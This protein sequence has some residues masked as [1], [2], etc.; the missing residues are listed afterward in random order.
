MAGPVLSIGL[1][2]IFGGWKGAALGALDYFSRG[3]QVSEGP[4]LTDRAVPVAELGYRIPK[5]YGTVRTAGAMIWTPRAGLTEIRNVQRG[6]SKDRTEYV[7]YSYT[8][9][10]AWC[11]C[12]PSTRLRGVSYNNF[13]IYSNNGTTEVVHPSLAPSGQSIVDRNGDVIPTDENG[14]A[15]AGIYGYKVI[16]AAA[17]TTY[18]PVTGTFTNA[19]F[20]IYTGTETQLPDALIEADLGVGKTPAYRGRTLFV[21][22]DFAVAQSVGT[23]SFEVEGLYSDLA[24]VCLDIWNDCGVPSALVDVSQLASEEIRGFILDGRDA[25]RDALQEL[26][27]NHYFD[28]VHRDGKEVAVPRGGAIVVSIPA[29]DLR[30]RNLTSQQSGIDNPPETVIKDSDVLILPQRNEKEFHDAARNYHP[31]VRAAWRDAPPYGAQQDKQAT[32]TSEILSGAQAQKLADVEL[33]SQWEEAL[34][35]ELSLGTTYRYLQPT[36]P[37]EVTLD[38][39]ATRFRTVSM[40]KQQFG[41]LSAVVVRESADLYN[42]PEG[43]DTEGLPPVIVEQYGDVTLFLI[44]TNAIMDSQ[45]D[46]IQGT[47]PAPLMYPYFASPTGT[48]LTA[49]ASPYLQD[50]PSNAGSL[51][52]RFR[53]QSTMGYTVG[54]LADFASGSAIW[55]EVSTLTVDLIYGSLADSTTAALEADPRLNQAFVNQEI[56]QFRDVTYLGLFSGK[57][58]YELSGLLRGQRGTEWAISEHED[59]DPF[60]LTS[61]AQVLQFDP[62]TIGREIVLN[63]SV[64]GEAQALAVLVE[65]ANLKPYSPVDVRLSDTQPGDGGITA[66]WQNRTRKA[67][68]ADAWWQTGTTPPLGETTEEYEVDILNALG[69]V[70][71]RFSGLTSKSV[72]WTPAQQTTDFGSP[73]SIMRLR[74]FQVSSSVGRGYGTYK[75]LV[76]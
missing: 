18:D 40:Q 19:K 31:N 33:H 41:G 68:A 71:R 7:S 25:G 47:A 24:D 12:G 3:K 34:R 69:G 43:E 23:M 65:G 38:G 27:H 6:D 56:V 73:Q 64:A 70:V 60:I 28:W 26:A 16:S 20:R 44:Q 42:A 53:T 36:D 57:H 76:V 9:D 74:V 45:A 54:A 62:V 11:V 35:L 72:T 63:M 75:E 22:Q 55:D 46:G 37:I 4:R 10:A 14:V 8:L 21:V 29:G 66:E 13:P 61:Y 1:G 5:V 50:P 59:E 58:R 67:D 30:V 48:G 17:Q 49:I 2:G 32:S 39:R 15:L 51:M 52:E